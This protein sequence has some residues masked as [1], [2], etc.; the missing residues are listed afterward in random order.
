MPTKD[1]LKRITKQHGGKLE[2]THSE[3]ETSKTPQVD[4]D[5]PTE[6]HNILHPGPKEIIFGDGYVVRLHEPSL[7]ARRQI[8]GFATRVVGDAAS[9]PGL[10]SGLLP[11]RILSLLNAR[12]DL[13]SELFHWAAVLFDGPGKVSDEQ[14][15]EFA[16]E[17]ASHA[18]PKD[19]G[20][21]YDA[22][23]TIAGADFPK[24]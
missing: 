11:L 9:L 15:K 19:L 8:F 21:L 3:P 2:G 16:D 13:S 14:A 10:R 18:W 6:Q 17:I 20:P 12:K 24:N 5:D 1:D 22:I 23:A 7:E 4:L